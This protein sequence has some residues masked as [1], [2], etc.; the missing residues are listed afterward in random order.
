[1]IFNV[2]IITGRVW[3]QILSLGDPGFCIYLQKDV[4]PIQD[5]GMTAV[6]LLV[7]RRQDFMGLC[8]FLQ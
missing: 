3:L 2:Y 4:D 8:L 7:K 6:P 5:A 1:M